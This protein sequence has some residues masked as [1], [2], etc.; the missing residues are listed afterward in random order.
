MSFNSNKD[1]YSSRLFKIWSEKQSLTSIEVHF[2]D[3]YPIN[4]FGMAIEAGI[5]GGSII[6]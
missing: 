1:L 2:L 4:T 3:K 6:F 5:G